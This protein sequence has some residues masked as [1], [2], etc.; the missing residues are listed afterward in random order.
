MKIRNDESRKKFGPWL[1]TKL[2]IWLC[3][4]MLSF[5]WLQTHFEE[6]LS[7]RDRTIEATKLVLRSARNKS[8]PG[9]MTRET[10][11]KYSTRV[12]YQVRELPV[13]LLL[14][15]LA[16]ASKLQELVMGWVEGLV[17][18]ADWL[19]APCWGLRCFCYWRLLFLLSAISAGCISIL[20]PYSA[21]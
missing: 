8:A 14:W 3:I 9:K 20:Q 5:L 1:S 10:V 13:C 4:L 15:C 6:A 16:G 7:V 18:V 2:N 17:W 11:M 19:W 21:S 12:S